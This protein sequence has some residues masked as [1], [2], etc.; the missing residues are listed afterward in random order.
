MTNK[1]A[2]DILS[3]VPGLQIAEEDFGEGADISDMALSNCRCPRCAQGQVT[4]DI[5]SDGPTLFPRT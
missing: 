1:D 2:R 3:M 5:S 4:D